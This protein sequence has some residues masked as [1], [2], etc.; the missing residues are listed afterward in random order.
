MKK[1]VEDLKVES[2]WSGKRVSDSF[3]QAI[4]NMIIE[5]E[6]RESKGVLDHEKK[7]SII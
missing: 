4:V 6:K 5:L 1:Q 3:Y 2:V 7:C